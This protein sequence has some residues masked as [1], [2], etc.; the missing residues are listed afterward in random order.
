V[1]VVRYQ[2]ILTHCFWFIIQCL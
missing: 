1:K 2:R